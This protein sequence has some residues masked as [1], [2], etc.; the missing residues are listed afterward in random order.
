[1]N[2]EP[3][4]PIEMD[5]PAQFPANSAAGGSNATGIDPLAQIHAR[6]LGRLAR[7]W[8]ATLRADGFLCDKKIKAPLP[9]H[10]IYMQ[11]DLFKLFKWLFQTALPALFGKEACEGIRLVITDGD[12]QEFTQLDVAIVTKITN[13]IRRRCGWHIENR[14]W[15]RNVHIPKSDAAKKEAGIVKAWLYSLM[16]DVE[17]I[18][19]YTM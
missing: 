17:T 8:P 10:Y 5:Q 16:K 19:E 11:Y 4:P 3:I 2:A 15:K 7:P 12:S 1:M 6:M 9:E 18:E 13:A 14:G